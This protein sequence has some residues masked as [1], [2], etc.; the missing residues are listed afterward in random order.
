MVLDIVK[1]AALTIVVAGLLVVVVVY[2]RKSRANG[3]PTRQSW[4]HLDQIRGAMPPTPRPEWA[5]WAPA[6]GDDDADG[7]ARR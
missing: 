3:F 2:V 5:N 7:H 6:E 1:G 4:S